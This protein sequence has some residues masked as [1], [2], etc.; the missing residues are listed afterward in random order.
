M[1]PINTP[2]IDSLNLTIDKDKIQVLDQSLTSRILTYFVDID[3]IDDDPENIKPPKPYVHTK[4][5]VTIRLM[6]VQYFDRSNKQITKLSITLS[7]KLLLNRYFQGITI[8]NVEYLYMELMSLNVFKC[9]YKDFL[10][11][12]VNDV[13]ICLNYRITENSF[14]KLQNLLIGVCRSGFNKFFNL[15][16]TKTPKRKPE[17]LPNNWTYDHINLGLDINTRQ[18]AKP[19]T[20][21]IKNYFKEIELQTKSLEFYELYLKDDLKLNNDTIKDLARVEYTIKGYRQKK[22][23]FDNSIL[24]HNYSTLKELLL[25][26]KEDF[27]DV[28]KSG[29]S[30]YILKPEREK[31]EIDK[32]GLSPTDALICDLMIQLVETGKTELDI[33][34]VLNS[35]VGVEKSRLKKKIENLLKHNRLNNLSFKSKLKENTEIQSFFSHFLDWNS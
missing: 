22:R 29:F 11:S 23:L 24:V 10:N 33:K 18:K 12:A 2:C 7:S 13:D 6:W 15:F 1:I 3:M 16:A 32:K 19:A 9:S 5:G 27:K 21:Y 34:R 20:P 31:F 26:P 8:Y 17:S 4:N 35:Y 28:I 14:L 25:I 30:D